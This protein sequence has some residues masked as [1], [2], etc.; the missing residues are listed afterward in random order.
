MTSDP[1]SGVISS[2]ASSSRASTINEEIIRNRNA[3]QCLT[4]ISV[5]HVFHIKHCCAVKF[6]FTVIRNT[7]ILMAPKLEKSSAESHVSGEWILCALR[8]VNKVNKL[9]ALL[10]YCTTRR[11]INRNCEHQY[12]HSHICYLIPL[13]NRDKLF[14]A[15][16]WCSWSTCVV[17]SIYIV[18][19]IYTE[20]SSFA[21]FYSLPCMTWLNNL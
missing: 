1:T 12:S 8:Q 17:S 20:T 11:K 18:P 13:A 4:F 16:N 3:R 21:L 2:C 19:G 15:N 9:T 10:I 14:R 7:R 5:N 6:K